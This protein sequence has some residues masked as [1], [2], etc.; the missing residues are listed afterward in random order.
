MARQARSQLKKL[1]ARSLVRT[2]KIVVKFNAIPIDPVKISEIP[3]MFRISSMYL[4]KFSNS[5]IE[6]LTGSTHVEL[7]L[8]VL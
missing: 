7:Q 6:K 4:T 1:A 2:T 5:T 3:S 8:E